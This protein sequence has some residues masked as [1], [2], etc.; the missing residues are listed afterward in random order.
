MTSHNSKL[1]NSR[2]SVTGAISVSVVFFF[3]K[4]KIMILFAQ[5]NF[6]VQMTANF[7]GQ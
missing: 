3:I 2:I 4:I 6:L 7:V 1:R 5:I